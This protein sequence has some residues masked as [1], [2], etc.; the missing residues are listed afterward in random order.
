M[1]AGVEGR[2]ILQEGRAG[3]EEGAAEMGQQEQT[4]RIL[5]A[6][7]ARVT[8]LCSQLGSVL[9]LPLCHCDIRH[10]HACHPGSD[11]RIY[12]NVLE[13]WKGHGVGGRLRVPRT[14]CEVINQGLGLF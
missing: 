3:Q 9:P 8:H 2:L 5:G 1:E 12:S 4:V 14:S 10:H 6:A 13:K 7:F 11:G